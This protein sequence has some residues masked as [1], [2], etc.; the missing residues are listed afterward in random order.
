V[1]VIGAYI[2]NSI[3]TV[4][5]S[6]RARYGNFAV[7]FGRVDYQFY[8]DVFADISYGFNIGNME[9][10]ARGLYDNNLEY[11][12]LAQDQTTG[13]M[14]ADVSERENEFTTEI[15]LKYTF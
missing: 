9:I 8:N 15:G 5:Y 4:Q 2:P 1:N 3:I 12:I 11:F 10:Y 6:H 7:N 14:Q 13:F